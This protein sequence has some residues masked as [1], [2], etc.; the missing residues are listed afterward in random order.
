MRYYNTDGTYHD[1]PQDNQFGWCLNDISID[2]AMPSYQEQNRTVKRISRIT[3]QLSITCESCDYD[4]PSDKTT[5]EL[6]EASISDS[7]DIEECVDVLTDVTYFS[8]TFCHETEKGSSGILEKTRSRQQIKK[9]KC[10]VKEETS[11]SAIVCQKS[12]EGFIENAESNYY[13]R[14]RDIKIPSKEQMMSLINPVNPESKALLGII[15]YSKYCSLSDKET[16]DDLLRK[17]NYK[18]TNSKH[19]MH[20][21][22]TLP[23]KHGIDESMQDKN[24]PVFNFQ[25]SDGD[26]DTERQMAS[27][28]QDYHANKEDNMLSLMM[29]LII[30]DMDSN[31]GDMSEL[32]HSINDLS[33]IGAA[34]AL[35]TSDLGNSIHSSIMSKEGNGVKERV[36]SKMKFLEVPNRAD[37]LN[38]IGISD[39]IDKSIESFIQEKTDMHRELTEIKRSFEEDEKK[40]DN[41]LVQSAILQNDLRETAHLDN[42]IHLLEGRPERVKNKKLPFRIFHAGYEREGNQNLII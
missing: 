10:N 4:D 13:K 33:N 20:E 42:L 18:T 29:E 32:N 23:F 38:S 5:S 31:L 8:N 12:V 21:Y 6:I 35:E 15:S 22:D 26:V 24:L 16:Q 37:L 28:I 14:A 17:I 25:T 40:I 1:H 3:R 9:I 34:A 30:T 2:E 39:D 7:D 36:E 19:L 27:E 41:L 11:L